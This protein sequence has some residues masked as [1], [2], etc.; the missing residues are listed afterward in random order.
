LFLVFI[1]NI[2]TGTINVFS[3][4][5][6]NLEIIINDFVS[7]NSI[8]NKI[9]AYTYE[10]TASQIIDESKPYLH[11]NNPKVRRLI[12]NN[13]FKA[14]KK[15]TGIKTKQ[16]GVFVL[17]NT[18]LFDSD[19][20]NIYRVINYLDELPEAYFDGK[21][22][23]RLATLILERPAHFSKLIRL[24]GKV[25]VVQL[26]AYLEVS[27]QNDKELTTS[28]IWN[29]N[30]VL[31]RWGD[32]IKAE[33]CVESVEKLGLSDEIVFRLVP[34][35]IYTQQRAVFNYLFDEIL[36]DELNCSSTDPDNEIEINCA[37]RL[38]EYITPHISDFPLRLTPSGELDVADYEEALLRVRA[39]IE[40]N[41][42][43]YQMILN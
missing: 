37:Y 8:Y 1:I 17:V 18:G 31:A 43:T 15:E 14:I 39:W 23:N 28:E 25:N 33:Y 32:E 29:V 16:K 27:L 38:L 6:N 20:G 35:L 5:I 34:D 21:T 30:L 19:A 12:Y 42:H 13:V 11:H 9:T 40:S 2:F 22:K 10:N 26:L 4:N 24:V 7:G 3:Q 41:R 36:K